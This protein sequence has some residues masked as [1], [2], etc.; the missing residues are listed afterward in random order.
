MGQDGLPLSLAIIVA[1][2]VLGVFLLVGMICLSIF[3]HG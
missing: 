1:S 2:A 3:L